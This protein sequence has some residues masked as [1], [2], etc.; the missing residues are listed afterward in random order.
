MTTATVGTARSAMA[1]K[2]SAIAVAWPR[3]SDPMPGSAPG[4]S[5]SVI[6]GNPNFSA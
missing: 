6:S 5:I 2:L 1:N 4:V 3:S